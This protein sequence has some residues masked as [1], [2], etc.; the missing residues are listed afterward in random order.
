VST[1]PTTTADAGSLI[2]TTRSDGLIVGGHVAEQRRRRGV[3]DVDDLKAAQPSRDEC[4]I[5]ADADVVDKVVGVKIADDPWRRW[6]GYVEGEE[7]GVVIGDEQQPVGEAKIVGDTH[8]FDVVQESW[9]RRSADVEDVDRTGTIG[10]DSQ[11]PLDREQVCRRCL[12]LAQQRRIRGVAEVDRSEALVVDGDERRVALD[13]DS[14]RSPGNVQQ[15]EKGRNERVF[16]IE[17]AQRRG[18]ERFF[19][20]QQPGS[21]KDRGVR[22]ERKENGLGGVAWRQREVDRVDRA[23]AHA[24]HIEGFAGEQ[25]LPL[26]QAKAGSLHE[27]E[28]RRRFGVGDVE[29]LHALIMCYVRRSV[30]D[31]HICDVV[32][33][34][35]DRQ[36]TRVLRVGQVDDVRPEVKTRDKGDVRLDINAE[37]EDRSRKRAACRDVRLRVDREYLHPVEAG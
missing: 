37:S 1:P 9:R 26:P 19:E 17:H 16:D 22:F 15:A 23:V 10:S 30:P 13:D 25:E 29:D 5:G 14:G 8:A 11:R 12:D 35:R 7:T 27:G 21:L 20:G 6:G 32:G 31:N 36:R 2:S 18:G 4:E 33:S 28:F 3:R 34:L 24:S